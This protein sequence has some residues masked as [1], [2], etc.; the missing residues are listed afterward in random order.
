MSGFRENFIHGHVLVLFVCRVIMDVDAQH[1]GNRIVDR[2]FQGA[3][4]EI[5]RMPTK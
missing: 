4:A 2:F 5:G 1:I 3:N